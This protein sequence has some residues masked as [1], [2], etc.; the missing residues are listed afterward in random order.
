M[1]TLWVSICM[2][3][4]AGTQHFIWLINILLLLCPETPFFN[5]AVR[6]RWSSQINAPRPNT[7]CSGMRE[8]GA[9]QIASRFVAGLLTA[10][11][12]SAASFHSSPSVLLQPFW[13]LTGNHQ[14]G[15]TVT[16]KI[17]VLHISPSLPYNAGY[18]SE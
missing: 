4:N 14:V 5:G 17:L 2:K 11:R 9:S 8:E 6:H 13:N 15:L 3:G 18:F 10:Q 16:A 12:A 1:A 7:K